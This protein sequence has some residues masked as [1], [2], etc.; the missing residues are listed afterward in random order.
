MKKRLQ[1]LR[2]LFFMLHKGNITLR[3]KLLLYLLFM[4]LT[5]FG[6]LILVLATSGAIFNFEHQVRQI[7]EIKADHTATSIQD[8]MDIMTGYGDNMAQNLSHQIEYQLEEN[9][10]RKVEG[11]NNQPEI[12]L[13]IQKD[14]FAELSTTL[15]VTRSSGTYAAL[16]ATTN[17]EAPNAEKYR[18]GV[19]L[20]LANVGNSVQLDPDIFYFRGIPDIAREKGLELHNRWNLEFNID[21]FSEFKE[22]ADDS[23]EK[24]GFWTESRR[25]QDSWEKA[26]FYH[27]P[28]YGSRGEFYGV[29][30]VELSE[31]YMKLSYPVVET[32]FGPAITLMAPLEKGNLEIEKGLVG[33]SATTWLNSR[34]SPAGNKNGGLAYYDDGID[35]YLGIEKGVSI[36]GK[37]DQKWKVVVLIPN[38][39]YM[40]H[41][42]EQ[43]RRVILSV[44]IFI[45][46][47]GTLSL[48]I[49]RKFV[50]PIVKGLEI[51]Q[52]QRDYSKLSTGISELD[53]LIRF[54]ES[55][56]HTEQI[57]DRGLPED[58][59]ELLVQ[60]AEGIKKLSAAEYHVFHFYL[61]GYSISEIPELAFISM[62]TVKK[63]NRNIYGKL[64]ISSNDELLL[65]IDL[66]RR[67]GRIEELDRQN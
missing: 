60:F 63:H 12:L 42:S 9:G 45:L 18:S 13:A 21:V 33:G 37:D 59:E 25:I 7:L 48:I 67:C 27:A 20:R 29:C 56:P 6:I 47:M 65:L 11:L 53:V 51:I 22:F 54:L 28:L 4:S 19:Y 61:E 32:E 41:V 34:L 62:S 17:T 40:A 66:F 46:C 30:G 8:M 23:E 49:S 16:N 3:S 55:Q 2:H 10:L 36:S 1:E 24:A 31:L 52:T 39:I 35:Q 58:I 43:R 5:A 44:F 15:K 50:Q 26:M 38:R 57:S 14:F 64:G